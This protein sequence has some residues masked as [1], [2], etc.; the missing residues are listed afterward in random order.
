MNIQGTIANAIQKIAQQSSGKIKPPSGPSAPSRPTP[1]AQFKPTSPGTG[2]LTYTKSGQLFKLGLFQGAAT[3]QGHQ[4]ATLL[5]QTISTELSVMMPQLARLKELD[6]VLFSILQQAF[7]LIKDDQKDEEELRKKRKREQQKEDE[8]ES[9]E[10]ALELLEILLEHAAEVDDVEAFCEWARE[11][12]AYT[13]SEMLKYREELPEHVEA[14]FEIMND[15]ILAL[16][17][18]LSPEFIRERLQQEIER[19]QGHHS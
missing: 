11:S 9:E 18:G 17:N 5:K 15:A 19:K 10:K 16:E 4:L 2:H 6:Q 12:V 14:S 3:E 13:R 7:T 1:P 8:S